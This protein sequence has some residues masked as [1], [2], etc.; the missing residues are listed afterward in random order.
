MKTSDL[1]ARIVAG[2]PAA[3]FALFIVLQGGWWFAGG[4]IALGLI[5]LH[6]LFEM[7][8]DIPTARLAGFLAVIALGIVALQGEREDIVLVM[9]ALLPVLFLLTVGGPASAGGA[10]GMALVVLGVAWIGMGIAHAIMLR[11]LPHGGGI[12]GAVL[13]GTFVGDTGAYF[14]GRAIGRTKL[15]PRISPNKTVEGLVC[16][17]LTA[18]LAVWIVNWYQDW[19]DTPDA[20]LLGLGVAIAAPLG[21]L[22]ES[23]VKRDAGTKDTGRL[24]GAHGGALDRLD[25]VLFSLIVGFYVWKA[26]GA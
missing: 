15:A 26:M 24:F 9:V 14:G 10:F 23:F 12:V 22:F 11:E 16:G 3:I 25:A 5:C 13:I 1:G 20:L 4:A 8:R 6:E 7:F 21:D 18:V 17:I 2:V 19:I